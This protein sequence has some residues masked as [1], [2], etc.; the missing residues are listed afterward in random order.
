L[1]ADTSVTGSSF[2]ASSVYLLVICKSNIYI[3]TVSVG[4]RVTAAACTQSEEREHIVEENTVILGLR[5]SKNKALAAQRE[6]R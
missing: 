1:L 4:D 2:T 6:D 5:I 3:S